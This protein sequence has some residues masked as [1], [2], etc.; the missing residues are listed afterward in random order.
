M[1]D[2]CKHPANENLDSHDIPWLN[3]MS[4]GKVNRVCANCI[5][6]IKRSLVESFDAAVSKIAQPSTHMNTREALQQIAY[7]N[8]LG[9]IHWEEKVP[10]YSS[11]GKPVEDGFVFVNGERCFFCRRSWGKENFRLVNSFEGLT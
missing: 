10:I 5:A 2:V 7:K 11:T 1:C 8:N 4:S 9:K 6:F 3:E